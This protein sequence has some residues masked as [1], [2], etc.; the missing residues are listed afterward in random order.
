[1]EGVLVAPG[2]T[3]LTRIPSFAHSQPQ[4]IVSRFIAALHAA[5]AAPSNFS[6]SDVVVT[7]VALVPKSNH[8]DSV[9]LPVYRIARKL[10]D[11]KTM[12]GLVDEMDVMIKPCE[13]VVLEAR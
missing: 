11:R 7:G 1:M 8:Q 5:Y 13:S 6:A 12:I 2:A 3:A 9:S 10:G 4:L